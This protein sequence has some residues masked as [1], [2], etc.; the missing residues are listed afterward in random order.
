MIARR[1]LQATIATA[2]LLATASTAN[3]VSVSYDFNS[4][5]VDAF[6]AGPY[7]TVE[8]TQNSSDVKVKVTLR[9][10]LNFVNTG[11]PHSVFSFNLAGAS[12]G[13]IKS[14]KFNGSSNSYFTVVAPGVNAPFGTFSFMIDCTNNNCRNGSPGQ[15]PDPLT[16]TVKNAVF[17]DFFM[18]SLNAYFAADVICTGTSTS[19]E[20]SSCNGNSGCTGATGAIAVVGRTTKNVPEPG[21][22]A[23]LG[24]GLLGLGAARRR[25]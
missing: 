25:A 1:L 19:R 20:N 21:S 24:L 9:S 12:A 7:G 2:A 10:D 4:T 11:G 22:L 14:I 18:N 15:Q 3:A 16:F 13:D 8:L 6:G 17:A 23:L 5:E